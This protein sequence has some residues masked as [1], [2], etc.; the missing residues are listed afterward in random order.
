[1]TFDIFDSGQTGL[2]YVIGSHERGKTKKKTN[3]SIQDQQIRSRRDVRCRNISS[4]LESNLSRYCHCATD[5]DQSECVISI[6]GHTC[7][8]KDN[9]FSIAK[10][11]QYIHSNSDVDKSTMAGW[12]AARQKGREAD[13]EQ[14]DRRK[15]GQAG[16]D[17]DKRGASGQLGEI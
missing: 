5:E 1:M 16:R 11:V 13:S 4:E 7:M 12:Q 10:S 3:W 9:L 8:T 17:R 14:T 15:A 2:G 6:G